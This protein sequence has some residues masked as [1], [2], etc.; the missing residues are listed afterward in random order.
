MREEEY[1]H[2][3]DINGWWRGDGICSDAGWRLQKQIDQVHMHD[4]L[5]FIGKLELLFIR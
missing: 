3:A 1:R 4:Y 5:P 2:Y